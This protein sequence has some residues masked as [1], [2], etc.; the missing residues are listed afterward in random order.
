M[1]ATQDAGSLKGSCDELAIE[2][3][4]ITVGAFELLLRFVYNGFVFLQRSL[5]LLAKKTLIYSANEPCA[6]SVDD[7]LRL[8]S[9]ATTLGFTAIRTRAI[10][11]LD[12]R[13]SDMDPVDLII[14][15][16]KYDV[17]RWLTS[18]YVQL[19][20]RDEPLSEAQ[21]ERLGV[22]TVLRISRVRE[23]VLCELLGSCHISLKRAK[24]YMRV[25]R[26]V[27]EVFGAGGAAAAS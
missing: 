18:A 13:I 17:Q 21:G 6:Y 7:W 15:A 10:S 8:L 20:I 12:M 9:V 25:W 11:E 1:F 14:T 27:E 22:K 24:E 16:R 5:Q 23:N 26:V 4:N 3:N 2:L 19:C